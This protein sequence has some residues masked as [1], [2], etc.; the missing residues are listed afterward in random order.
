MA[1]LRGG[2]RGTSGVAWLPGKEL[3]VLGVAGRTWWGRDVG[4]GRSLVSGASPELTASVPD[5][6]GTAEGHGP[7]TGP[8]TGVPELLGMG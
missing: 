6:V 4:V 3:L 2:T 7:A 8:W 5:T 1:E